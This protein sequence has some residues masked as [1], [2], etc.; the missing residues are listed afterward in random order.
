MVASGAPHFFILQCT[1]ERDAKDVRASYNQAVGH[2]QWFQP[3]DPNPKL[4]TW[5]DEG[6]DQRA[7]LKDQF[8]QQHVF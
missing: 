5:L 8:F 2:E 4:Q 7:D 6:D 3:V 1:R